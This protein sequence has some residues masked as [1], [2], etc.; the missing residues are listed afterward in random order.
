MS[1]LDKLRQEAYE[2]AGAFRGHLLG[3]WSTGD[4]HVSTSA[5]MWC[6]RTVTV[7]TKPLPNGIDIGGEAVAIDCPG[8]EVSR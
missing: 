5:C 6:A 7:D 1:R 8:R 3:P 4:R 2:S